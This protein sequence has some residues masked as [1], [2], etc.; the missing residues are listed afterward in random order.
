MTV[1]RLTVVVIGLVLGLALL[2]ACGGPGGGRAQADQDKDGRTLADALR[3]TDAQ[4]GGFKLDQVTVLTGGDVPSGKEYRLHAVSD[5]VL[6]DSRAR[7]TYHINQGSKTLDYDVVFFADRLYVRSHAGPTWKTAPLPASTSLFPALRLE[8]LR[9]T[10]LLAS[11]VSSGSVS[12]VDAGF[13][14]KYA[15]RPAPDQLEQLQ[16]I[17]VQGNGER[18]FL[19]TATAEVDL[20]LVVPGNRLGRIEV[21]LVGIDPTSGTRQ[22]IDSGAD[23]HTARVD[24]IAPPAQAVPV[25]AGEILT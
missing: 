19:K 2:T 5:G 11:S 23:L 24:A 6:K 16:S 9:E 7:F 15:V 3:A 12:H 4:G 18:Q 21:H 1:R 22:Q 17:A 10:V 20:F 25:A 8:L 13:A 14:R